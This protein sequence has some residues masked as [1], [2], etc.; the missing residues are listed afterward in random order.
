MYSGIIYQLGRIVSLQFDA[1]HTL[2][3]SVLLLKKI[4]NIKLGDSI[5]INGICLTVVNYSEKALGFQAMS[6][7]MAI[8][9]I[10][11]WKINDIVHVEYSMRYGDYMGGHLV[12]GHVHT[13]GTLVTKQIQSDGNY[14]YTFNHD[15]LHLTTPKESISI[16]GVSLTIAYCTPHTL[17]VYIIPHTYANTLFNKYQIGNKVNLEFQNYKI[18]KETLEIG[19]V[20]VASDDEIMQ[21]CS[22]LALEVKDSPAPNPNVGCIIVKNHKILGLGKHIGSGY[23]HAETNAISSSVYADLKEA[24]MY[25]TLEPCCHYGK[26]PPCIQ[27]IMMTGITKIVIGIVDPDQKVA[28]KGIE[29]LRESGIEV[30]VLDSPIVK[31]S[32][33]MYIHHRTTGTPYII[34]KMALTMNHKYKTPDFYIASEEALLDVHKTRNQVQGLLTTR[35]TLVEDDPRLTCRHLGKNKHMPVVCLTTQD[36]YVNTKYPLFQTIGGDLKNCCLELGKTYVS[37]LTE[38]G[39]TAFHALF[40]NKVWKQLDLYITSSCQTGLSFSLPTFLQQPADHIERMGD[41]V[42]Y[43]YYV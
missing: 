36:N 24:T 6:E 39:P 38:C 23:P 42:K 31:E 11:N 12:Y 5:A 1:Q 32:L 28:G 13:I 20:L 30:V 16:D 22:Q 3:L 8:T 27:S 25:V 17:T 9:T 37:L 18:P 35:K 14:S 40:E 41:T 33:K 2:C 21:L 26:T 43:T 19:K 34:L 4:K 15:S 10:T 29:K 7:T